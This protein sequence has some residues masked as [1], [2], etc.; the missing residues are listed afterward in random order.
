[1]VVSMVVVVMAESAVVMMVEASSSESP[2]MV[3]ASD[4]PNAVRHGLRNKE[5]SSLS[6][7]VVQQLPSGESVSDLQS[8]IAS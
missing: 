4:V 1:M 8:Q 5:P 7:F 3:T 2:A 6:T